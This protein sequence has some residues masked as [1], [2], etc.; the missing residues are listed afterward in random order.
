MG[1]PRGCYD[2]ELRR[3]SYD[4]GL[5]SQLYISQLYCNFAQK[6]EKKTRRDSLLL[7][8]SLILRN[9]SR[10][11][12]FIIGPLQEMV[13]WHNLPKRKDKMRIKWYN[14][15]EHLKVSTFAEFERLVGEEIYIYTVIWKNVVFDQLRN[16]AEL[17]THNDSCFL[18]AEREG[19][20]SFELYS[21]YLYSIARAKHLLLQWFLPIL[22]FRLVA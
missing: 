18:F 8:F 3:Q 2:G 12:Y 4:L 11:L 19:T 13:R 9:S 16:C 15:K 17:T 10:S 22:P 7:I 20:H 5:F 1:V 6:K 21:P 14:Q